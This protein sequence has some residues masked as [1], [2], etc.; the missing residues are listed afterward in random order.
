[1]ISPLFTHRYLDLSLRLL[2]RRTTPVP[3]EG[4]A[5]IAVPAPG[6]GGTVRFGATA[7]RQHD[8]TTCGAAVGLLVNAAADPALATWLATGQVPPGAPGDLPPGA[9]GDLRL[10]SNAPAGAGS[11]SVLNDAN[12][13]LQ[14]PAQRLASA[15]S[16]LHRRLTRRGLGPFPWPR[17]LGT[18]PWTLAHGLRL[19]Q[20]RYA[21]R[22]VDDR[23]RHLMDRTVQML[24]A[25]TAAGIPVPLYTGGNTRRGWA[26]AVPRHVVLALPAPGPDLRIFEP[27]TARVYRVEPREL[28]ARTGPHPAF[29]NWDHLA[30]V[31]I[32]LVRADS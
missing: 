23:D 26:T 25:A 10:R 16:V 27:S 21:H 20:V 31:L 5:T 9:P 7:A 11:M 3:S 1:M 29:G 13:T 28:R 8:A 24:L 6:T 4:W 17:S 19:P 18:P 15:Q 2:A 30:W 14:D 12:L 22:P 32:P